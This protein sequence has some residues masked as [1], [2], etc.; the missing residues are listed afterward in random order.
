MDELVRSAAR[1][2]R[3]TL[4]HLAR[5]S[6]RARSRAPLSCGYW[7]RAGRA[8]WQ[9]RCAGARLRGRAQAYSLGGENMHYGTPV[10]PA[11]PDRVPGGSSSGSAVRGRPRE[12]HRPGLMH[13]A[14]RTCLRKRGHISAADAAAGQSD[15]RQKAWRCWCRALHTL[16]GGA[17][18]LGML[19]DSASALCMACVTGAQ[20]CNSSRRPARL[21]AR[22]SLAGRCGGWL[23]GYRAG[24]RHRRCAARLSGLQRPCGPCIGTASSCAAAKG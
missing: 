8:P 9:G 11:C 2:R 1:A 22:P 15:K 13:L 23:R 4:V 17:V 19:Q 24:Q 18:D 6:P 7:A 16:R 14:G 12:A 20:P 10:N 21:S 5:A 3:S